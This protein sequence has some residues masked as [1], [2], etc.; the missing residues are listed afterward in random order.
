MLTLAF[1][2]PAAGRLGRGSIHSFTHARNVYPLLAW[3]KV[4]SEVHNIA[5]SVGQKRVIDWKVLP[6]LHSTSLK[7]SFKRKKALLS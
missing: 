6:I 1:H 2:I 5:T 4:D 7:S 3:L